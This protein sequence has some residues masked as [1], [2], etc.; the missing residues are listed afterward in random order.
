M[1][2]VCPV[3]GSSNWVSFYLSE[4][5][6]IM[7]G[8][9]R[10]QSGSLNKIICP[11]SGVVANMNSFTSEDIELLYGNEYELNT[12]GAEEH[13]FFTAD[14]PIA[15]SQVFFNWIE[16][17]LPDQ[18]ES[19]IEIGCGE[20]NLLEKFKQKYPAHDLSGIDGSYKASELAAKKGLKVQQKLLLGGE[21]LPKTDVFLLVNVV[22]HVE[23]ISS[24]LRNLRESLNEGGRIIFCLPIQDY[25]GYD[26]FF[27]EHVWHFTSEHFKAILARNGLRLIDSDIN[28][29]INH[30]IG[31]FVCETSTQ[32]LVV[33]SHKG[34]IKSNLNYWLHNFKK[35]NRLLET[36]YDR[37][38]IF[39]AGEVSTLFLAFT[40]LY[41]KNI[42]AC[43]DDTKPAGMYKHGIP[44]YSS[45]WLEEN[46]VDL[47]IL[48]INKKY[49]EAVL[50]RFAHLKLKVWP[51]Y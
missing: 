24:F 13:F 37:I 42:V 23:D 36:N 10:I 32:E 21:P 28:H 39:G 11:D 15:R 26:L 9:Q 33:P 48:T 18:F 35:I 16:C 50:K 1:M 5:K 44:V 12:L 38:A 3:S 20:G 2:R 25:G 14:G 6:R 45:E 46:Q 34:E 47:L 4:T 51:V 29:P 8:D 27:Y 7:T 41:L 43:I 30:G 17:F 22:E 49:H 31:L 40:N 19:L